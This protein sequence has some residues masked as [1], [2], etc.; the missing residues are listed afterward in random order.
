MAIQQINV[1]VLANDG[2]GDD[3]REAF[4]KANQNFDDLDL[5]VASF[6]EITGS[7]LGTTG[8]SVFAEKSD[9]DFQFRKLQADPLY[10]ET[11]NL[12][13]SD[14]GNTIFLSTPQSRSRFTDGSTTIT[15][16][17]EQPIF[18]TGEEGAVVT[19]NT[20]GPEIR[21]RSVIS[22][23]TNPELSTNLNLAD[24]EL[25]NVAALNGIQDTQFDAVFKFDFG[26]YDSNATSVIDFIILNTDVDLGGSGDWAESTA[27]IEFG[28]VGSDWGEG[29]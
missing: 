23:E 18:V 9:N 26:A 28:Q 22:G 14:D 3:L 13:T 16:P 15:T 12:R 1:G 5:R 17:V 6:T 11:I 2:T 7:N 4:I 29:A 24:N 10:A 25:I 19:V 20:V 27:G 8:Y 21:I